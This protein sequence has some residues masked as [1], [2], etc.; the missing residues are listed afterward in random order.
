MKRV[1]LKRLTALVMAVVLTLG[2][3][4]PI[5]SY[6]YAAGLDRDCAIDNTKVPERKVPILYNEGERSDL[7]QS[8]VVTAED[9]V[10]AAGCGF[11][12]EKS[13]DGI[14]YNESAVKISYYADRGFFDGNKTG[15]YETY[16]LVEPVSGKDAY[17]IC[18]T[19]SVREPET[20]V[21]ES[22]E[23]DTTGNND[24]EEPAPESEQY[25]LSAGEIENFG[26]GDTM[27]IQMASLQV[28]KAA[29]KSS[30]KNSMKVA[31]SLIS[32]RKHRL[33]K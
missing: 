23:T 11:D 6:S 4:I 1:K 30:G 29:A 13:F 2:A 26:A 3:V 27:M 33:Q 7:E 5:G 17:L 21:S 31:Y 18:R 16:Y 22:G 8:E 9:I 19:I 24:D 32:I 20:A 14:T 25:S 12:V 15:S 10:I 28:L